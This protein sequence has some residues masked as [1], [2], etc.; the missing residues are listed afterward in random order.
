MRR[1]L[2]L[3]SERRSR[4][5]RERATSTAG[6]RRSSATGR[7]SRT[8]TTSRT[9]SSPSGS[10][11][12][13][14]TRARSSTRR[15]T[16]SRLPSD[17]SSTTS[18]ASCACG[19]ASACSTS[20]AA[21]AP[22]HPCRAAL[23]RAR[24]SASRSRG[25]RPSSPRRASG[26]AGLDD[27]CRVELRDYR[28]VDEP[29]GFD[30]LVSLG[31]YEHVARDALPDYFGHAWRLLK[32]GGVFLAHGIARSLPRPRPGPVRPSWRPTSCPTTI[33][34]RSRPC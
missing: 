5:G 19:P 28:E 34:C 9:T 6:A 16:T 20:A 23:R 14:R 29:E 15:P 24:R 18:A 25:S 32:P 4:V 17:G 30:K 7:R 1:L 27:R 10:T 11:R 22:G 13:W 26:E 2:A 12:R 33:S 8:T 21:G 3:P 31:M